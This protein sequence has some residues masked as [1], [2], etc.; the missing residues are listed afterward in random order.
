M[1]GGLSGSPGHPVY[2]QGTDLTW[3]LRARPSLAAELLPCFGAPGWSLWREAE[4]GMV[5]LRPFCHS[6]A[7]GFLLP[8]LALS[9][10]SILLSSMPA[11]GPGLTSA[12]RIA[13]PQVS[14]ARP[15]PG[16]ELQGN[17]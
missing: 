9:R 13:T 2:I 5:L 15:T 6:L 16:V 11:P 7:C 1:W 3:L 4:G 8:S 10:A 17:T 14:S 12:I